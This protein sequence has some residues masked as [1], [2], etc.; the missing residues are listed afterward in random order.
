MRFLSIFFSLLLSGGCSGRFHSIEP[1]TRTPKL[2]ER[3]DFTVL[4]TADYRNAYLQEEVALD[5]LIETPSGEERLLPCFWVEGKSGA[6][7]RWEARFT[8]QEPGRYFCR[9]RLSEQGEEV[10]RSRAVELS[11]QPAAE[12]ERG[13]LHVRDNWTLVYDDGTPF[14]GVA[15]NIC[16]ESRANDDSKFFKELHEQHDRYNYDRM[17][18]LF[19]ENGGNFIRVWM[20]SFNFPIDQHDHFNNLRYTPSDEY[21]NPSAVERLDC[22][23]DLCERLGIHVML[24]MGQGAVPADRE[25]FNGEP[26]A[27]RY[28]NRLRYIVARWGYSPAI[29]MWEFFN[30]IDNIQH[31]NPGGP[32]PAEEIVAWHARMGK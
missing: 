26:Q 17:L 11:V 12:G 18:P 20:C 30:E 2:Y 24:C 27:R 9:F 7:S 3:T 21:Y 15:E 16:W 8:P 13:I 22:F 14:R 4:L 32:I 31:R 10:A 19:A 28:M 1:S 5:M 25:F 23:V 6:E 29:G